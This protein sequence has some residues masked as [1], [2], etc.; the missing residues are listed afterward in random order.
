MLQIDYCG[1]GKQP[2]ESERWENSLEVLRA[3][4]L[5]KHP[6]SQAGGRAKNSVC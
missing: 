5:S 6:V 1:D 4:S 3:G 2:L